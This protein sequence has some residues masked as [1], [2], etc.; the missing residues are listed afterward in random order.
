MDKS[1]GFQLAP[2]RASGSASYRERQD[3]EGIKVGSSDL[4]AK[5]NPP[6]GS[7]EKPTFFGL[8]GSLRKIMEKL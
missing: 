7:P 4:F 3:H 1:N 5:F 6:P 2:R 8:S